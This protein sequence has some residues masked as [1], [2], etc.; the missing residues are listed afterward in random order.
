MPDDGRPLVQEDI[1][2][3]S[4]WHV[5]QVK[6]KRVADFVTVEILAEG[7]HITLFVKR[8]EMEKV[9]AMLDTARQELNVIARTGGVS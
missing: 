4:V 7:E 9:S 8:D 3:V 2:Q 1:M 5:M 6:A